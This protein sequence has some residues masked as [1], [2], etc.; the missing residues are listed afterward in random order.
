VVWDGEIK[1]EQAH[2]RANQPFGLPVRQAEHGPEGQ[3]CQDGER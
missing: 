1:A 2:E 3:G